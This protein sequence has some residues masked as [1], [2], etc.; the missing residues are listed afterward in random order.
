MTEELTAT[1]RPAP[2]AGA[3]QRIDG[4]ERPGPGAEPASSAAEHLGPASVR[5]G[6]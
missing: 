6:A 1:G 2:P 4:S 5:R 3:E